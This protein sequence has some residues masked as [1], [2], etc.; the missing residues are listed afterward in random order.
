M[1]REDLKELYKKHYQLIIE[2]IQMEFGLT[3][4]EAQKYFEMNRDYG[5]QARQNN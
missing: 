2:S 1:I 5:I 3:T 4:E